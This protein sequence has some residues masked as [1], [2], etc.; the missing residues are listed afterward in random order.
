MQRLL[1]S[2]C[3][4]LN[5]LLCTVCVR[6]YTPGSS[7][8]TCKGPDL[9]ICCASQESSFAACPVCGASLA[10]SILQQHAEACLETCKGTSN[11]AASPAE[12]SGVG[13]ASQPAG[14]LPAPDTPGLLSLTK[15][16]AAEEGH[17]TPSQDSAPGSPAAG[18]SKRQAMGDGAEPRVTLRGGDGPIKLERT[19]GGDAP[20]K[21]LPARTA[22]RPFGHAEPKGA[23]QVTHDIVRNNAKPHQAAAAAKAAACL[24]GSGE[25]PGPGANAFAAMMSAQRELAQVPTHHSPT[26]QH[27]AHASPLFLVTRAPALLCVSTFSLPH[28]WHSTALQTL[29]WACLQRA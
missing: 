18:A 16:D 9:R 25:M 8:Q 7:A 2:S 14:S 26:T 27:A 13:H 4:L 29:L 23:H 1:T 28:I 15:A 10:R 22:A 17:D 20:P 6:L 3:K 24:E 19:A 5:V 11:N 12:Q 21:L